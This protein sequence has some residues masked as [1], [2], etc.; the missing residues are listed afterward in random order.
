MA[1]LWKFKDSEIFHKPVDPVELGIPDYHDIIKNPMDF[2]TI[3]KKLNARVYT[4]TAEFCEDMELVFSN[5]ELYNGEKSVIGAICKNVRNEYKKL[6]DQ[7]NLSIF[8]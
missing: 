8:L 5:C 3:K 6:F 4:N 1:S 2:S 7:Y